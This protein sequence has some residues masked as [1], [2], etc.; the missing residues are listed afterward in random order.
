MFRSFSDGAFEAY[1][2]GIKKFETTSDGAL[3]AGGLNIMPGS[4]SF[5]T[6][7]KE[8]TGILVSLRTTGTERGNISSNG[9]TVQFNTSSSDKSMKKNFEDWTENTLSLITHLTLPTN[10]S[11]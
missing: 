5:V 2:N 9:S 11:V 6:V 3:V 1:H 10:L 8:G 7:N 4:S